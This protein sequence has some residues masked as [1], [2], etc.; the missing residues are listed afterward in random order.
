MKARWV[1]SKAVVLKPG[2]DMPN[3]GEVRPSCMKLRRSNSKPTDKES[4]TSL[5]QSGL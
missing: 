2:F 4:I 5:D 1:K 3:T